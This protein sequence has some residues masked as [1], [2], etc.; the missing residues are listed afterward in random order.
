M[1]LPAELPDA[2]LRAP[3][4]ARPRATRV[5]PVVRDVLLV[6][7]GAALALAVDEWRDARQRA[8]RV[9]AALAGIRDELRGNA[10]RIEAARARHRRVA[11][12]LGTLLARG[13][14]PTPQ[15]YLNPMFSPALVTSTAWQA[16]RETGALADMPLPTVLRLAPA[17]EAQ[18]RYRALGEAL[19]VGIMHDVRRDGMDGVLRDRFGQFIPLAVDF[20]T[21]RACSSS[22]TSAPWRR[23]PRPLPDAALPLSGTRGWGSAPSVPVVCCQCL[24]VTARS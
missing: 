19:V 18:E 2:S 16:A 13:T 21:A 7:L 9:S 15:V 4:P 5:P 20:G 12:T 11:D 22:T 6:V 8:G 3:S 10:R 23:P 24:A 17:Y 1:S 14:R